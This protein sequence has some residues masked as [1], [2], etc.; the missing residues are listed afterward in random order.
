MSRTIKKKRRAD[1]RRATANGAKQRALIARAEK[2]V[3]SAIATWAG[4]CYEIAC[5]LVRAK[6]VPGE[7]VYGHWLGPIAPESYF[8]DQK[9][10]PFVRHGW[11]VQPG[12]KIVDPT[13]WTFTGEQPHIYQG[14]SGPEYDEGGDKWRASMMER[15]PTHDEHWFN[16]PHGAAEVHFSPKILAQPAWAHVEKLVNDKESEGTI[17]GWL[18][19]T[20][21]MWLANVPYSAL[22]EHAGAIYKALRD[23][24]FSEFVPIDNKRRAEREKR[25][26]RLETS[27]RRKKA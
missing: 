12:G 22:G 6:I 5:T 27:T 3:G 24:G 11:I 17:P 8:A 19:K 2:A 18:T 26:A 16:E 7:A 10:V 9:G 14:I 20:Q 1:S 4:R 15:C 21:T 23:L 25:W 13:R